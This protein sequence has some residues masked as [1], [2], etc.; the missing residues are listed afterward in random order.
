MTKR[1]LTG[2]AAVL[3][4]L[5]A[6][7]CSS[8]AKTTTSTEPAAKPTASAE[9][10]ANAEPATFNLDWAQS[11]FVQSSCPA[12]HATATACYS[13]TAT[14]TLP[15]IGQVALQR[16]V[17]TTGPEDAKGCL[18]AETDG[19]LTKSGGVLTF[20]AT[21]TLCDLLA[22]YKLTTSSGTGSLA[23]LTVNGTITNNSG[24]ETWTGTVAHN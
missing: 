9:P 19:T 24:S 14:G 15:E 16:A 6:G 23:G 13:G 2:L 10:A 1:A 5:V 18:V 8:T 3:V 22:T 12:A 4:L 7:G 20:H 17:Y 21:G 11:D